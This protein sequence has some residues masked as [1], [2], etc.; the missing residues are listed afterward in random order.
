MHFNL[1][2]RGST[3]LNE[4]L[5]RFADAA[6]EFPGNPSQATLHRWRLRGVRGVK[7]ETVLV[8][9]KRFTSFSALERFSRAVTSAAAGD[10]QAI[11]SP[12]RRE[13]AMRRAQNEL[14]RDGVLPGPEGSNL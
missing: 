14:Q 10:P 1:H 2:E 4:V 9:G 6:K 3:M 13:S 5:I 11:R 8:G 7:L 12:N